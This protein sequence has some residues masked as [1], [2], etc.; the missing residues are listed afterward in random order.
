MCVCMPLCVCVRVCPRHAHTPSMCVCV[1]NGS[2]LEFGSR[3][4]G[5]D[6][7]WVWQWV[8]MVTSNKFIIHA[9]HA[10]PSLIPSLS[11]P[12]Y[13]AM[14][15]RLLMCT[16]LCVCMCAYTWLTMDLVQKLHIHTLDNLTR[17]CPERSCFNLTLSKSRGPL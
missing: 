8:A 10:A 7:A 11:A 1:F 9:A 3:M 12:G 15:L 16:T 4:G 5:G 6:N 14:L 17:W 2:C 13:E